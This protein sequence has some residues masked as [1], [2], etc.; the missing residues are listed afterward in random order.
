M[1]TS[2]PTYHYDSLITRYAYHHG[3]YDRHEREFRGFGMVEQWDTEEVDFFGEP[4]LFPVGSNEEDT[5]ALPPVYTKTWF[6]N[7]YFEEM[8]RVSQQFKKEYYQGDGAAWHL[9]DSILPQGLTATEWR[10]AHRALKGQPLRSEV[11]HINEDGS[12]SE[13]YTVSESNYRVR[14]IQPKGENRFAS[15]QTLPEESLSYQYEQNPADPRIAHEL[16]LETDLYGMPL[17]S[18]HVAYPRR[19]TGHPIPQSRP[20]MVLTKQEYIHL[21]DQTNALRLAIP[22][23]VEA[24][25]ITG[26]A[27][28]NLLS[29]DDLDEAFDNASAIDYLTTPNY[30]SEQK[31]LVAKT[32]AEYYNAALSAALPLGEAA[33]HALPYQSYSLALTAAMK[34]TVYGSYSEVDDTLLANEGGYAKR[35]SDFYAPS[36]IFTFDDAAFFTIEKTTDP[37]G[38]ETHFE[39]D[40]YH[41]M[42]LKTTDAYGNEMS[43]EPDYRVLAPW[44]V[45]D[46]NGNRQQVA[47]DARGM[48]VKTAVMGKQGDSDGDTLSDPT[49]ILEYGLFNWMTHGQPNYAHSLMRE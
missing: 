13:P 35:G 32:E 17:R 33:M 49:G 14:R 16:T 7:G 43:V 4:G 19:G 42:A 3:Y 31:R 29:A 37:F 10:E 9:P 47:F 11:Y 36:G 39:Y 25:E 21:D 45:T 20:L 1:I 22:Y 38:E 23:R 27:A 5:Y 34:S 12:V 41:L 2:K 40:S 18:A 30:S 46:P 28:G 8:N 26:L 6:H 48:V 44:Q 15:F 24:W